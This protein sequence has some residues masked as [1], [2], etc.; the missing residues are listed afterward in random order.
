MWWL[1]CQLSPNETSD[2][3]KTFVEWSSTSNRRV[4]KKWQIELIDQ[5]T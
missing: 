3:Q 2:I 1:W 5:V 4:P